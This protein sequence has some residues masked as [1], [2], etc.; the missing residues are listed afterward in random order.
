MVWCILRNTLSTAAQVRHQ[1]ACVRHEDLIENTTTWLL[2]FQDQ[3]KLR[4]RPGFPIEVTTLRPSCAPYLRSSGALCWWRRRSMRVPEWQVCKR[5]HHR[6]LRL[7]CDAVFVMQRP[8]T[9]VERASI[10]RGNAASRGDGRVGHSGVLPVDLYA[11]S[12]HICSVAR[13]WTLGPRRCST[14]RA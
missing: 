3:F 10:T 13:D 6:E 5:E 9:H 7:F 4:T 11:L 2:D 12:A 14:T 8:R 1:S